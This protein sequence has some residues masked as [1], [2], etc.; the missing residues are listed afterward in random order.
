MA[1][2]PGLVLSLVAVIITAI[3]ALALGD[4]PAATAN[5]SGGALAIIAPWS[6]PAG[7]EFTVRAFLRETRSLSPARVSGL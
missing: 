5:T 4:E 3:P 1:D 6:V 7:R 2:H